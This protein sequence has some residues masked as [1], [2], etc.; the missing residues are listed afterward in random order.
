[1][2]NR[3]WN[4][5]AVGALSLVMAAAF[6]PLDTLTAAPGEIVKYEPT[7]H[8]VRIFAS[9]GE[10][11]VT[12][13]KSEKTVE[14]S[15][16][17]GEIMVNPLGTGQCKIT[18]TNMT[19]IDQD[20]SL[21]GQVDSDDESNGKD[22]LNIS[23]E[24]LD[25]PGNRAVIPAKD[26]RTFILT[27]TSLENKADSRWISIGAR[28]EGSSGGAFCDIK[29]KI[30]SEE[31]SKCILSL[32]SEMV[33]PEFYYYSLGETWLNP[34][35]VE[36][37]GD[38]YHFS[39]TPDMK[40]ASEDYRLIIKYDSGIWAGEMPKGDSQ[41]INMSDSVTVNVISGTDDLSPRVSSIDIQQI[42]D[43]Y[44]GQFSFS[45]KNNLKLSPGNYQLAIDGTIGSMDIEGCSSESYFSRIEQIEAGTDNITI[46][47]AE[48]ARN[49]DFTIEGSDSPYWYAK[50]FYQQSDGSWQSGL[51]TT[52][53]YQSDSRHLKCSV[54]P[55]ADN[56][57]IKLLV[58]SGTEMFVID[59]LNL[60]AASESYA[61]SMD[62][63][64]A[65]GRNREYPILNRNN[66]KQV[67]LTSRDYESYISLVLKYE[68]SD[69]DYENI[70]FMQGGDGG[71]TYYLPSGEYP[72]TITVNK[73]PWIMYMDHMI[74]PENEGVI[75][76]DDLV[77]TDFQDVTINWAEQFDPKLPDS[78][79][80]VGAA[81]VGVVSAKPD[82]E[83]T[84][85]SIQGMKSGDVIKTK[86]GSQEITIPLR[87]G[88][89]DSG[90]YF[91]DIVR[92]LDSNQTTAV[93]I[94]N[95][96][97]GNI[98]IQDPYDENFYTDG[99]IGL[100][101]SDSVDQ[102][103]NQLS[104]FSASSFG[105]KDISLKGNI[106]Y[107]DVNSGKET[108][109]PITATGSYVTTQ[110]PSEP[111]TY[112]ISLELFTYV[113]GDPGPEGPAATPDPKP[114][115]PVVPPSTGPT[116]AP[117]QTPTATPIPDGPTSTPTPG[118]TE[119]PTATPTPGVT[120]EP[121]KT[122]VVE[123]PDGSKTETTVST[124][125]NKEGSVIQTTEVVHKS[126]DG[127]VTDSHIKSILTDSR[128]GGTLA[129]VNVKKNA[130]GTITSATAVL[131]ADTSAQPQKVLITGSVVRQI[132]QAAGT[133]NV[134][135]SVRNINSSGASTVVMNTAD[136][137]AGK[138]LNIVIRQSSGKYIL[139]NAKTYT[140]AKNGDVIAAVK[141][142]KTYELISTT[143]MN[144][145]SRKI[146]K[147][148]KAKNTSK[149]IKR[150]KPVK[151]ALKKTLNMDNVKSIKYTVSKRSVAAVNKKGIVKAKKAGTAVI[152]AKVTLKNGRTKTVKMKVKV[153]K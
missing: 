111:G 143:T 142:S 51:G 66:L 100:S 113:K 70:F 24:S 36:Q 23:F 38:S 46:D 90:T 124:S 50:A 144:T 15:A 42:G 29:V 79:S 148:I 31:Q 98:Q 37:E 149:T 49:F 26:S 88:V 21:E 83:N 34:L 30:G 106:T 125:T 76:V 28:T 91:F 75:N 133:D 43:V 152:H 18:V 145:L 27:V 71:C 131:T 60:S 104:S 114:V 122:A 74:N 61:I 8:S 94:G 3:I 45:D 110:L 115:V 11:T 141:G 52:S 58:Y 16:D 130:N 126:A 4:R 53:L 67:S 134:K 128:N 87:Q 77:G 127:K 121:P 136:L 6:T 22:I 12:V 147:T 116:G 139:V 107:T 2:K 48:R 40:E 80:T 82:G 120:E 108:V 135:I 19:G 68:I 10:E 109:Q 119:E 118:V 47:L 56:L 41:N 69:L 103:G 105:E 96:F 99:T 44:T 9:S 95:S 14:I 81:L 39:K 146:L 89:S 117:T 129:T 59:D 57:S 85:I 63:D 123:R 25:G 151:M 73:Y 93:H 5:V 7:D 78:I 150:S 92:R 86:K 153:K 54:M 72:S 137:T 55:E 84:N 97:N 64:E 35:T 112:K 101:V 17:P 102:E 65:D 33:N 1:M 13:Q 32:D 132:T 138:K 140:V 62:V 20:V